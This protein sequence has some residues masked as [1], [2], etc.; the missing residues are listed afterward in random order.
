MFLNLVGEELPKIF[1]R[2]TLSKAY[3]TG[4]ISKLCCPILS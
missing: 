4:P 2:H 3:S 1:D